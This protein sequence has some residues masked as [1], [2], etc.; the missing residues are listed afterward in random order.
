M[1]LKK[2]IVILGAGKENPTTLMMRISVAVP[3]AYQI[4]RSLFNVQAVRVSQPLKISQ[5]L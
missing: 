5:K 3:R 4:L 2:N 1:T